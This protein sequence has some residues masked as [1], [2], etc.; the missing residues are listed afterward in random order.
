MKQKL[1]ISKLLVVYAHPAREE[2]LSGA[3]LEAFTRGATSAGLEVRVRDLYA[4]GFNPVVSKQD[5]FDGFTGKVPPDCEEEQR[6]VTWADALAFIAPAWNWSMPAMLK[7]YLD[8]AFVIPGFSFS[9]DATGSTY[10]GGLLKH[11]KALIL[12]TLGGN[13][14]TGFRFGNVADYAQGLVSAMHYCGIRNTHVQQFWN[15]YKQTKDAPGMSALLER[16]R[17]LGERFDEQDDALVQGLST[18]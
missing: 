1:G 4:L 6:H 12:Q 9:S 18:C 8:R 10:Q 14:Q 13:L 3:I 7:G 2:S 17:A 16:C 11:K 15:M 5:W